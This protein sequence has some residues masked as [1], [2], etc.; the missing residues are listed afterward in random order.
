VLSGGEK[1]RVALAKTLLSEANF[2][3]LDEPTNHLDMQ[4]VQILIQALHQYQGSYLVVSHDRHFIAKIANK[5]WFIEDQQINSYPGTYE[6]YEYWRSQK[7]TTIKE[8]GPT[9][10]K[11]KGHK[12]STKPR[13]NN[14]VQKL[15]Q[16]IGKVEQEIGTLE[17]KKQELEQALSDPQVFSS[18]DQLA[19]TTE[20]F[21][22]NQVNLEAA[23]QKWEELAQQIDALT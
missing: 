23:N 3:L 2:L 20:Q 5:I 16:K 14:E 4:S 19:R 6:E 7:Q 17:R 1:S 8:Q 21:Q 13:S 11:P 10:T 9:N 15:Q 22:V 12:P 18:P